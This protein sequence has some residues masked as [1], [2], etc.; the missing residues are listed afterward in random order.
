MHLKLKVQRLQVRP[1]Y[2]NLGGE[3]ESKID[4]KKKPENSWQKKCHVLLRMI[5]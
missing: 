5:N 2:R 1:H 4:V 3:V